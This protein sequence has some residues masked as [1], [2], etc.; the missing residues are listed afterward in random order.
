MRS[1]PTFQTVTPLILRG[2][3]REPACD[4]RQTVAG[5]IAKSAAT[6][7]SR[8]CAESGNSSKPRRAAWSIRFIFGLGNRIELSRTVAVP[9]D[10]TH[11]HH[12]TQDC[13][14]VPVA[15]LDSARSVDS[16][17]VDNV[18]RKR[19][20]QLLHVVDRDVALAAFHGPD[21]RA[22]QAGSRCQL[23]LGNTSAD[24]PC[25]Q[26]RGESN[27]SGNRWGTSLTHRVRR[28]TAMNTLGLQTIGSIIVGS[29]A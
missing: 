11:S 3:G 29:E 9:A 12:A 13:Q 2:V 24:P 22:M 27:A 28:I 6:T 4:H 1:A 15:H 21:I 26:I 19:V 5:E 8:T 7:G 18:Q 14:R 25:T 17:Q 20:R 23:L 10:D 16:Q